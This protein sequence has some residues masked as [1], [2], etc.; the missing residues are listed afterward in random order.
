MYPGLTRKLT[1][2]DGSAMTISYGTSADTGF[3]DETHTG[4]QV[5][6]A[7]FGLRAA[8]VVGLTDQTG[9]FFTMTEALGLDRAAK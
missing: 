2:A 7:A 8:N 3:E 1:T 5:R 4:T 6:I 9:L